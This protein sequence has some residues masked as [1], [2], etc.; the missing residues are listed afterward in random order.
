MGGRE[1]TTQ[2][3]G[4]RE[5]LETRFQDES[6]C[7]PLLLHSRMPHLSFVHSTMYASAHTTAH[8][9]GTLPLTLP[10]SSLLTLLLR[11]IEAAGKPNATDYLR[12]LQLEAEAQINAV[13]EQNGG[14]NMI[15]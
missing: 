1:S 8:L 5:G 4:E 2:V 10:P 14:L 9:Q 15:R 12:P 6:L 11:A 3:G 13:V 7:V